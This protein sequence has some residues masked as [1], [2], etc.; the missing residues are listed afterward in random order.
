MV[1][2]ALREAI[3]RRAPRPELRDWRT[4]AGMRSLR[5]DAWERVRD[6][7]T[8]VEEVLRVVQD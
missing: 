6:G 2:D 5:M 8:T 4:R 7:I 3:V 1:D